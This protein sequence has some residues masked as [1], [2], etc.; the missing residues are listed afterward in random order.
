MT[1]VLIRKGS[2]RGDTHR[3]KTMVR[4]SRRVAICKP[5]REASEET[6]LARTLNLDFQPLK[7]WEKEILL[8]KTPV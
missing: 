6:N 3:G 7:L 4:D 2:A 8:F 1:G 5:R